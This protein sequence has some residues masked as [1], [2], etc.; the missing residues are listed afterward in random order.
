MEIVFQPF[1]DIHL[2]DLKRT[3]HVETALKLLDL[4][5]VAASKGAVDKSAFQNSFCESLQVLRASNLQELVTVSF[6]LYDAS[7]VSRC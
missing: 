3:E 6:T 4:L 2:A 1:K 7:V 5:A